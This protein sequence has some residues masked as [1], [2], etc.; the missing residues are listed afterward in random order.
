MI[1]NNLV[2]KGF[3][4]GYSC[5][6]SS[7]KEGQGCGSR[8]SISRHGR[9][10]L[11]DLLRMSC[12]VCFLISSKITFPELAQPTVICAPTPHQSSIKKTPTSLITGHSGEDHFLSRGFLFLDDCRWSQVDIKLA[13][14]AVNCT[15][16]KKENCSGIENSTGPSD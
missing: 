7:R 9:I 12:L 11:T 8:N 16:Q 6:P 5:H 15:S 4:S 2:R 3:T 13:S 14:I 1:K 10:M